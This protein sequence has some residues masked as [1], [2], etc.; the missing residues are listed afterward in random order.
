MIL[1]IGDTVIWTD[2]SKNVL[3]LVCSSSEGGCVIEWCD[4]Y[5][6]FYI[7]SEAVMLRV[8][9]IEYLKTK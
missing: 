7:T 1:N 9:L 5:K 3:G 4:G 8:N 6:R 2:G